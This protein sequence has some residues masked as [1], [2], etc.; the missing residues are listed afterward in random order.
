MAIINSIGNSLTGQTG[1]GS[2]VG[3]AS[4]TFT[5]VVTMPT[6][7]LTANPTIILNNAAPYIIDMNGNTV[8]SFIPATSAV[9]SIIIQ[10]S[11]TTLP[12][13]IVPQGTDT[14]IILQLNGQGNA[15]V[16]IKGTTSG[17]MA[18][19]GDVGESV[20]S[21][22]VTNV[23]M[24]SGTVTQI[25]SLSLTMGDWNIWATFSTAIG[26]GTTTSQII[27]ALNLTSAS[28]P[29][30]T[31][32]TSSSIVQLTGAFTGASAVQTG[33]YPLSIT[34]TTTIY[35]NASVSYGV[36]TLTGGGIIFARRAS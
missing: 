3:S 15:G 12:A 34:A 7:Q 16:S 18:G 2:F 28:I 30:P 29:T 10:N 14:N 35:L 9:N 26:A 33:I 1:T 13:S 21:G 25:K 5:G 32:D 20:N 27:A 8:L 6:I 31:D 23:A 4:P 22:Y 24:T 17:T 11:A 19:G 36:S